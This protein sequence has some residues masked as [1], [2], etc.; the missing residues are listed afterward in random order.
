[1]FDNVRYR[2]IGNLFRSLLKWYMC[3]PECNLLSHQSSIWGDQNGARSINCFY[4]PAVPRMRNT[5]LYFISHNKQYQSHHLPI[6]AT[7]LDFML[8]AVWLIISRWTRPLLPCCYTAVY[9]LM[10]QCLLLSIEWNVF[11][12]VLPHSTSLFLHLF[13]GEFEECWV[14]KPQTEEC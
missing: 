1:M 9:L 12:N 13:G 10:A 2:I 6:I 11:F 5:H 4:P 3:N 8:N 7:A 14:L